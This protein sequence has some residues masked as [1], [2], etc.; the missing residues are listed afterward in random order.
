M[1]YFIF[2]INTIK[3]FEWLWLRIKNYNFDFLLFYF[4]CTFTFV[5]PEYYK[6]LYV[7]FC[8]VSGTRDTFSS[9]SRFKKIDAIVTKVS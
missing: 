1:L 9:R 4:I 3:I 6:Y 2:T 5:V 8:L 7:F